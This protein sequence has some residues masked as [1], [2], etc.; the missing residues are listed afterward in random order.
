MRAVMLDWA[1]VPVFWT[2]KW[3]VDCWV[4]S[5]PPEI[6]CT[7]RLPVGVGEMVGVLDGVKLGPIV[8]VLV[9]VAVRVG[10]ELGPIVG[11]LV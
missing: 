10:V 7:L 3:K 6:S 5:V 1:L 9:N 8:N 2:W 11:V 4:L